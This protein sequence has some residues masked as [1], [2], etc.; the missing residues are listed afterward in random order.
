MTVPP[1]GDAH[2]EPLLGAYVLDALPAEEAGAVAAHLRGCDS[3]TAAYLDVADASSLL[4]L[5][6]EADLA[7]GLGQDEPPGPA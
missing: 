5:L 4:A 7:E 1:D 6:T 2:V 3:C